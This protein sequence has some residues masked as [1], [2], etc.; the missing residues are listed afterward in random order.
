MASEDVKLYK[1]YYTFIFLLFFFTIGQK[2]K[3]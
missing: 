3:I 1:S 2:K